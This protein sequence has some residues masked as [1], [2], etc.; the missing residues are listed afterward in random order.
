M[1]KGHRGMLDPISNFTARGAMVQ[2]DGIF[3]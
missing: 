3:P 1:T 2:A